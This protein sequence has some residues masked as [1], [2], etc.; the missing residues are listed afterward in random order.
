MYR[1]NFQVHWVKRGDKRQTKVREAT[2]KT[3][4]S[5]TKDIFPRDSHISAQ[6]CARPPQKIVMLTTLGGVNSWCYINSKN[7]DDV[8]KKKLM[9]W[10]LV[11]DKQ[12]NQ[13]SIQRPRAAD[14][15]ESWGYG[16]HIYGSWHGVLTV[17]VCPLPTQVIVVVNDWKLE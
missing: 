13:D 12:E 7:I 8:L 9:V 4:A 17:W 6:S 16:H 2:T 10:K 15:S 5:G 11:R 1:K 3:V 14:A